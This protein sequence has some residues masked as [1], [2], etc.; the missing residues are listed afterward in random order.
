MGC[1]CAKRPKNTGRPKCVEQRGVSNGAVLGFYQTADGTVNQIPDGT[2]ITQTYVEGKLA[3]SDFEDRW[4][5]LPLNKM[6][7]SI[8]E[9]DKTEDIEGFAKRTGEK[10]ART[11]TAMLVGK[12][13]TPEMLAA[14]ESLQCRDL[15]F[16]DLTKSG[17]IVGTNI[18]DGD[19]R[20]TKIESDTFMVNAVYAEDGVIQKINVSWIIDETELDSEQDYIA[21]TSI[22][23]G[24]RFWYSSAPLE[25]VITEVSNYDLDTIEV[26]LKW[27]RNR[28]NP[29]GLEGFVSDDFNTNGVATVYNVTD[30]APETVVAVEQSDPDKYILTLASPVDEN[31]VVKVDIVKDGY[32]AESILVTMTAA[33]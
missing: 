21:S 6:V 19:L 25:V 4:Y 33:S 31:D 12:D 17:Q 32:D 24:V 3:E 29:E 1:E 20:M 28:W 27:A 13:A 8:R 30:S 15:A 23:Y 9:D 22:D 16:F 7:S 10:G 14:L 18:G 26:T 5:V 2:D 11:R